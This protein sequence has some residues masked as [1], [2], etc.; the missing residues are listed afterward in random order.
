FL[1]LVALAPFQGWLNCNHSGLEFENALEKEREFE[2]RDRT[3]ATTRLGRI[4]RR[5][6]IR[7]RSNSRA[8][9]D[10][11]YR[12]WRMITGCRSISQQPIE[13]KCVCLIHVGIAGQ[14]QS[15]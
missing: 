5:L 9:A 4:D 13:K 15:R 6:L 14:Q 8:A 11:D 3:G 7:L 2:R 12:Q 10:F 1:V